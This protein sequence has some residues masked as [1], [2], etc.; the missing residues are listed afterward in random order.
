[1]G[2]K[3][4]D[5]LLGSEFSATEFGSV[6]T[7]K[8]WPTGS[9]S[10]TIWQSLKELLNEV[11]RAPSRAADEM[12]AYVYSSRLTSIA[13]NITSRKIGEIRANSTSAWLR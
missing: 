2:C 12:A 9:T 10:Q 13:P 1:M 5:G 3:E 8:P 4:P 6:S 7:G 11:V